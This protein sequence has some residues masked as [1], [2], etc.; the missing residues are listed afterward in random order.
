MRGRLAALIAVT[1]A[2]AASATAAAAPTAPLSQKGRWIT[3]ADG[4]VVVLHGWNMVH[5]RPPYYPS[6]LGFSDDDAMFLRR[7]GFNTIRLGIIHKALEPQPGVYDDAY[8]NRILA[9]ARMLGRHGIWVLVD[10]HQDML[11]E[12]FNGEGE[13]D[14]VID[15]DGLPAQPDQGFPANYLIM[16]ALNRAFDHFWANDPPPGGGPGVLDRYSAAWRHVAT[17][18]RNERYLVG[19]DIFNEPWPGSQYPSCV[20]PAGCPAFDATL[21]AFSKKVIGRIREVDKRTVVYYEP[22]LTF[23]SGA[24]EH[25]ADPGEARGGFSFHIYCLAETP[26]VATGAPRSATRDQGCEAA[27][28]LVYDNADQHSADSG[29][30]LILTEFAASDD[31]TSIERMV[32]LADENEVSWQQWAYWNRDPCCPRPV[33]GLVVDPG[34]PPSGSNVKAGKLAVSARPFPHAVAGTPG[35]WR[36]DRQ[37]KVFELSY[38]TTRFGGGGFSRALDTEVA[39]PPV[40]YTRGYDVEL[41]GADVRSGLDSSTL[42]L[43]AERG[44]K[45][46]SVRVIPPR[47]RPGVD[48]KRG[49]EASRCL[50]SALSVGGRGIGKLR[51]GQKRV[52]LARRSGQPNVAKT[53]VLRWCVRGGGEVRAAL[54][55][56]RRA[57][58]VATTSRRHRARG[59][60]RVGRSRNV[61]VG[62]STKRAR[63]AYPNARRLA[64]GLYRTGRRNRVVFG[65]KGGRVRFIAVADRRTGKTARRLVKALRQVGLRKK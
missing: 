4:R 35:R 6:A 31:N 12:R 51:I 30:S 17:R 21:T 48:A 44:A 23:N 54:D 7:E 57:G 38:S 25:H 19:Y 24:A 53:R 33:E 61:R 64:R 2:C 13:P 9:T 39:V 45:A 46:V 60:R 27:E 22:N 32:R 40:Q 28:Q 59:A 42:R 63:L 16:P 41:S 5:K 20:S 10:F 1:V 18:F 49:S 34:K 29:D 37:K 47:P 43:R 62:N 50:P 56:R 3:D 14:W 15:D 52:T 36:F 26:G 65:V 55:S 58:L 11:N 8:I